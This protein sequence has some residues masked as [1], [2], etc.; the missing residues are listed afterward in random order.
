MIKD[1]AEKVIELTESESE[2]EY[3]PCEEVYGC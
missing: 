3:V 1:L 2:I